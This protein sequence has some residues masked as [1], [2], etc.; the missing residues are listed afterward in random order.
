MNKFAQALLQQ[1]A[2]DKFSPSAAGG[3]AGARSFGGGLDK[4]ARRY[5]RKFKREYDLV[6]APT[7]SKLPGSVG[8]SAGSDEGVV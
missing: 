8:T 7:R 4:V 1:I 2:G 3:K 6:A 5:G